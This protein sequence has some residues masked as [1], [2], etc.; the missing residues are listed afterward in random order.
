M[1][2]TKSSS[3]K[4]SEAGS[5]ISEE[6]LY[7]YTFELNDDGDPADDWCEED[8]IS[9]GPVQD[10][11]MNNTGEHEG[12]FHTRGT[13]ESE[14]VEITLD[15]SEEMVSSGGLSDDDILEAKIKA[16]PLISVHTSTESSDMDS[17][18]LDDPLLPNP[19]G[20]DLTIRDTADTMQMSA[21]TLFDFNQSVLCFD[22]SFNSTL[23][24]E[25]PLG[26]RKRVDGPESDAA[27]EKREYP[28]EELSSAG[29]SSSARPSNRRLGN[30]SDSARSLGKTSTTGSRGSRRRNL[31]VVAPLL[32]TDEH[33][34]K[35][36]VQEK[37][38]KSSSHAVLRNAWKKVDIPGSRRPSRPPMGSPRPHTPPPTTVNVIQTKSSAPKSS[39]GWAKVAPNPAKLKKKKFLKTNHEDKWTKVKMKQKSPDLSPTLPKRRSVQHPAAPPP[40][41]STA[42]ISNLEAS[43][44]SLGEMSQ[45]RASVQQRSPSKPTWVKQQVKPR[46]PNLED[47]FSTLMESASQESANRFQPTR[48]SHSSK[49]S[50]VDQS[51]SL[52]RRYYANGGT[53][54]MDLPDLNGSFSSVSINTPHARRL[55]MVR[56]SSRTSIH[57]FQMSRQSSRT[58]MHSFQMSRQS[59]RTSVDQSPSVPRRKPRYAVAD[60]DSSS[61]SL[62]GAARANK[63]N[64]MNL[65]D[66][67][68]V[69]PKRTLDKPSP[70]F[71]E[72]RK[73]IDASSVLS[74]SNAAEEKERIALDN[75]Q[76][77]TIAAEEDPSGRL[78]LGKD[79]PFFNAAG[80]EAK[81][82][83]RSRIHPQS[84]AVV[85]NEEAT[86]A[87]SVTSE[88]SSST[89]NESDPKSLNEPVPVI[90]AS[91][92]E[93]PESTAVP[94]FPPPSPS[95][96]LSAEPSLSKSTDQIQDSLSLSTPAGISESAHHST[97]SGIPRN[98][99][100]HHGSPTGA[101][102]S[103]EESASPRV[104]PTSASSK[105]IRHRSNLER[106][107][108]KMNATIGV[109]MSP[110]VSSLKKVAGTPSTKRKSLEQ[111]RMQAE[112]S[113]ARLRNRF[114]SIVSS[115]AN[116]RL[117]TNVKL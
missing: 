46:P 75:R 73:G 83:V 62:T 41:M 21:I 96:Q 6:Y 101:A 39:N 3:R 116:P 55:Q 91:F 76:S 78:R 115:D 58:S 102:R 28:P 11:E 104:L 100:P 94:P 117:E 98:K 95:A 63:Q 26:S 70:F 80:T 57:S 64:R 53:N 9:F 77:L 110:Q 14:Y 93:E 5:L 87:V 86:K 108:S 48:F 29:V 43:L 106:L 13:I 35:E 24:Q 16:R 32:E 84:S 109:R 52:P 33:S 74:H 113:L 66:Q 103:G 97:F 40:V 2:N 67:S 20:F 49:G 81:V 37:L 99:R 56:Q 72:G 23:S 111:K 27:E 61:H 10:D 18:M 19:D 60:L 51:P 45:S 92:K 71:E 105:R 31:L 30:K 38:K 34:P 69:R 68:P 1:P 8:S 54:N 89:E 22:Q 107:N 17:L 112:A 47:S 65:R 59:S 90:S 25:E 15:A 42:V 12:T 82:T 7:D 79:S 88:S 36:K 50:S 114:R 44:A 4:M 85:E